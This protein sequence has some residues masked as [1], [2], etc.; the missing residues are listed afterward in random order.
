MTGQVEAKRSGVARLLEP[1]RELVRDQRPHAVANESERSPQERA[2][3][4]RERIDEGCEMGEPTLGEAVVPARVDWTAQTPRSR[5][6]AA[7]ATSGRPTHPR[8]HAGSRRAGLVPA[9]AVPDA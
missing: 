6:A 2:D 7:A 9:A 8:P 1:A 4:L 5:A 3:R